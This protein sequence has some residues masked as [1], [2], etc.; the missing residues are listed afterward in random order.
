MNIHKLILDELDEEGTKGKDD[1]LSIATRRP[2]PQWATLLATYRRAIQF[3]EI[4]DKLKEEVHKLKVLKPD[5][6]E[7]DQFYQ[8]WNEDKANRLDY[9]MSGL[10]RLMRSGDILPVP[11]NQFWPSAHAAVGDGPARLNETSQAANRTWTLRTPSSKTCTQAN[12]V[13]W[14]NQADAP[15][16][17]TH[18]FVIEGAEDPLGPPKRAEGRDPASSTG[19]GSMPGRN[20]SGRCWKRSTTFS[21]NCPAAPSCR[22]RRT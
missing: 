10:R 21:S 7:F 8:L 5:Q 17:F 19:C 16:I 18:Q 9:Y 6:L 2:T 12:Y 22:A 15:V 4:A 20:W 3:F 14:I 1:T 11:K 13:K